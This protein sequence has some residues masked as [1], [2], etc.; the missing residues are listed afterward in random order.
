M[1]EKGRSRRSAS[2]RGSRRSRV[3]HADSDSA[4]ASLYNDQT[5][6]RDTLDRESLPPLPMKPPG[7]VEIGS[8]P[9]LTGNSA[10]EYYNDI[11]TTPSDETPPAPRTTSG[12]NALSRRR[13]SS[14]DLSYSQSPLR[15]RSSR[16]T[17]SHSSARDILRV[18]LS[19]ESS[20]SRE[21]LALL[22]RVQ[23]RLEV[24]STRAAEAERRVQEANER[25][26]MINQARVEAREEARKASE[27]LR[28]YKLQLEAAQQQIARA[29]D[30]I[31]L[32]EKERTQAED[33]AT[34]AKRL[35]KKLEM[36][37]EIQRA[38]EDGRREG[39]M[40]GRKEA[41]EAATYEPR[42]SPRDAY[43]RDRN[44]YRRRDRGFDDRTYP[45]DDDELTNFN[46][47]DEEYPEQPG[48]IPVA[49][50]AV[51]MHAR[52]QIPRSA[53][54][55]GLP[56]QVRSTDS[57]GQRR[58]NGLLD[59]ISRLGRVGS[60]RRASG[61]D[62]NVAINPSNAPD[63]A[64]IVDEPPMNTLS[65]P[66]P[67]EQTTQINHATPS[68]MPEPNFN[69]D[70][71]E[72]HPIAITG[73]P[74]SPMHP[75]TIIPPDGWI[76]PQDEDGSIRLP[77]PHEMA[78]APPTPRSQYSPL[79]NATNLPP[80][81][82]PELPERERGPIPRDFGQQPRHQGRHRYQK[83]VADSE[84]SIATGN[85]SILSP[86]GARPSAQP[87]LSA[88][89][90][91]DPRYASP[92]GSMRQAEAPLYP[93]SPR[94]L[95]IRNAD[96]EDVYISGDPMLDPALANR[97]SMANEG[98]MRPM[99]T[100][101]SPRSNNSRF[102]GPKRPS[103][104]TTPAPLASDS[105]SQ[106][107]TRPRVNSVASGSEYNGFIGTPHFS[108]SRDKTP[109][110]NFN[111]SRAGTAANTPANQPLPEI[112]IVPASHYES[113]QSHSNPNA[114]PEAHVVSPRRAPSHS[115]QMLS[116]VPGPVPMPQ[117]PTP[118]VP[119]PPSPA[120]IPGMPKGFV[121]VS[122]APAGSM[123]PLPEAM[124]NGLS[125]SL[126]VAPPGA[127]PGFIPA[128]PAVPSQGPPLPSNAPPGFVPTSPAI[129][130]GAPP[131][132]VPTSPAVPPGPGTLSPA[133]PNGAPPGFVPIS[134]VP[135][136]GVPLGFVPTSTQMPVNP[137]PQ[138]SPAMSTTG[139][140]PV[141]A[142]SAS[143]TGGI[144]TVT[145]AGSGTHGSP[146]VSFSGPNAGF[147]SRAASEWDTR[148]AWGDTISEHQS[149]RPVRGP[150]LS[151]TIVRPGSSLSRRDSS[152]VSP[153]A[154]TFRPSRRSS[155]AGLD[156]RDPVGVPLPASTAPS[157]AR[158]GRAI[159]HAESRERAIGSGVARS[160]SARSET[161]RGRM[162][163][164]GTP[165]RPS[166]SGLPP[167]GLASPYSRQ[168]DPHP[169]DEDEYEIVPSEDSNN[170]LTTPPGRRRNLPPPG[171]TPMVPIR[172][173]FYTRSPVASQRG[174][175]FSAADDDMDEPAQGPSL[176]KSA[177]RQ[178]IGSNK[179]YAKY[180]PSDYVDPA[181]LTSGHS[182]LLNLPPEEPVPASGPAGN[183][184]NKGK[185]GK[186]KKR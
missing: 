5:A 14:Q 48:E 58:S 78:Q 131:G 164:P 128:S 2:V 87:R 119:E 178:S 152:S 81:T 80:L 171:S 179:S 10:E 97:R 64:T 29:N 161:S 7:N 33:E 23:E 185:K 36:E 13:T 168:L 151:A 86:P 82:D 72:V 57:R 90:E 140:L 103:R 147:N 11:T 21:A 145:R 101:F 41:R 102:S 38:R 24:E 52:E 54:P 39:L 59:T 153:D 6:D 8:D 73:T 150:D 169:E 182:R 95:S 167:S 155:R 63:V 106:R 99:D 60:G 134:P 143:E 105:A 4:P 79:P 12:S 104:I 138:P 9:R 85:L 115:T 43:V 16:H 70:P 127:P 28:L 26:R 110:P 163:A 142:R 71:S 27:E 45:D 34:K 65:S 74:R 1:S 158:S 146:R 186:G 55:T 180:D 91:H 35:A 32:T 118:Q 25:W 47:D 170:T 133:V 165:A 62:R 108:R 15:G 3:S 148:S 50:Q 100:A 181:V 130:P 122:P 83:S 69:P 126:F 136:E 129:I 123:T 20:Q 107:Y 159:S 120:N 92:G 177:S 175:S 76:P 40:Q 46:I 113:S 44:H 67:P 166:V 53:P 176:R 56:G 18:L 89:P 174:V 37:R 98:P 75:P 30:M 156:G 141:L 111:R 172:N 173:S 112:N 31:A 183:K 84:D 121:P 139:A 61:M 68:R 125:A 19:A 17:R 49:P 51:S 96:P 109:A 154:T 94:P 114:M 184:K 132:F 77:P 66:L 157:L 137:L 22:R 88:I 117:P 160:Q 124:P 162:Y 135:P 93:T 144:P 42:Y 149:P 116:P